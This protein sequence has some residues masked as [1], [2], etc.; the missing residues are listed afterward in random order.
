MKL[1]VAE[2]AI[3][4]RRISAI[5]AE[6]EVPQ[7]SIEGSPAFE[8]ERAGEGNVMVPLRGHIMDVEFPSIYRYWQGTDL[9]KLTKAEVLYIDTEK[10][11]IAALKKAA[12][13]A[14][15]LIVATDADREG[16][17]IG[18]EAIRF[19]KGVNPK[20][21]IR[22]AY[23]SAITPKDIEASFSALEE[24]DYNL[25]DSADCRR[26]IDLIWGAVLTRFLSLVS[27]QMGKEFLSAGRVQTPVLAIIVDREKERMKFIS[28]KYWVLNAIFEKDGQRFLAEHKEG[29]FW[30]KGEADKAL[31]RRSD[32]GKV[33]SVE[34]KRRILSRPLPFNTTS[35]L[36]A[37]TH[38]GFSAGQA[39]NVAESL[40]QAGYTSY[41]RTDN[42]VYPKNTD[43]QGILQEIA[44]NAEFEPLVKK[45]LAKGA[46]DPSR[47]KATKDHPPIH[48]VSA[49]PKHK[50]DARSWKIYELIVRRF[51]AT[52]ADDAETENLAVTIDLNKEPYIARGQLIVRKGWKEFYHYSELKEVILPNLERGDTVLLID[53]E[54]LEK[55]TL[56]PASYSQAALIKL[57]DEKGIGTKSTRHE[58]IQKLYARHYISGTKAIVPNKIAFSVIDA[59]EKYAAKVT[60]PKMT[61]ELEQEM[62]SIAAGKKTKEL[63][64]EESR[65]MLSLI[66][67]ELLEQK[68]KIGAELRSAVRDDAILGKC[69]KCNEGMLRKLKS[70]NNKF[71]LACNKY[72]KCMNTYPLPQKGR[73]IPLEKPCPS[74]GKPMIKV[75]GGRFTYSMCIDPACPSKAD[76]GKKKEERE[77]EKAKAAAAA[78]GQAEAGH[79]APGAAQA[80]AGPAPAA[81][82]AAK[83]LPKAAQAEPAPSK[84]AV[85]KKRGRQKAKPA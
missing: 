83:T 25:A 50:L 7:S 64:V 17:S 6:R 79:A 72:P 39:M 46:L 2:K 28:K 18:A 70:R 51:L 1:I 75:A 74:C 47:G 9:K 38:L 23:F 67:A 36:R 40:Y 68:D 35:F 80:K 55:E 34:R 27:G 42:T 13:G 8:F 29:R 4:G 5:L 82:S 48:P 77:A 26:E 32:K 63:V 53:L 19:V 73:I 65:E 22:R 69:D 11:I 78:S 15:E 76:W 58:I 20:I 62:D 24:V 43:M 30:E 12:K 71:F 49:A 3:A 60:E 84:P 66:L 52:L 33:V 45:I 16:E 59:L 44:K 10:R 85:P 57:M 56:P 21:K 54:M 81:K 37:A 61:A 31:A 41:P 14:T